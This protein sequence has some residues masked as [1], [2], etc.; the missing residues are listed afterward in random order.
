VYSRD[1]LEEAFRSRS[2]RSPWVI[3]ARDGMRSRECNGPGGDRDAS[4]GL[5]FPTARGVVFVPDVPSIS[6]RPSV[7]I[8]GIVM[9]R[10][11]PSSFEERPR[12]ADDVIRLSPDADGFELELA[13]SPLVLAP[14]SRYQ[15]SISLLHPQDESEFIDIGDESHVHLLRPS[16]GTYSVRVRAIGRDG[17]P[18]S[19]S[20]IRIRAEPH[21]YEE[22]WIRGLALALCVSALAWAIRV[23]GQRAKRRQAELEHLVTER[24][25][26]LRARSE[27]LAD[28]LDR[29]SRMQ[30]DL[31]R[32][33]RL[34]TT[35]ILVRGIAHELRNPLGMI[36]GNIRVLARYTEYLLRV[37][38]T[39]RERATLG[40]DEQ[41]ALRLSA[42]KGFEDVASDLPALLADTE[43]GLR[44]TTLIVNDL[45][46]LDRG[47]EA[48]AIENTSIERAIANARRTLEHRMSALPDMEV[49]CDAGT[50]VDTYAGL[51]EQIFTNLLANAIDAVTE[52][53]PSEG[54]PIAVVVHSTEDEGVEISIAD[55][56]PGMSP[57]VLTRAMEPFF[58][59]KPAGR[60]TGL[61]LAI[62]AALVRSAGGQ[63]TIASER[64]RGTTVTFFLPSLSVGFRRSLDSVREIS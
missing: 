43:E 44:R 6:P 46:D 51:I 9:G 20:E 4:G 1:A 47:V 23:R 36:S 14:W 17:L 16:P 58:T 10:D 61:G 11:R 53:P 48:R 32:A 39:L 38:R 22:M 15:Y 63:I 50:S 19:T 55:R 28:A 8:Q 25:Q 37:G 2:L 5:W 18:G 21:W 12:D 42:K 27:S 7:A 35:A 24:T 49:E 3:D 59:T 29:L 54:A 60:G 57:E 31:L 62:T 41:H 34:A 33:E 64:G 26:E 30:A 45:G 40:V 52:A 56:G 13:M